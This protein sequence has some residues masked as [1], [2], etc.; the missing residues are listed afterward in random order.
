VR[1]IDGAAATR[2]PNIGR[3][4]T[5]VVKCTSTGSVAGG[6]PLHP[7]W[8]VVVYVCDPAVGDAQRLRRDGCQRCDDQAA[9]GVGLG[10]GV[11]V[12]PHPSEASRLGS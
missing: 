8:R 7:F 2:S 1:S 11:T 6:V 12:D 10:K 5:A 9:L 4:S 3:R